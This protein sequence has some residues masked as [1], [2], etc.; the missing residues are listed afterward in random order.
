MSYLDE[1][2][3]ECFENKIFHDRRYTWPDNPSAFQGA[4]LEATAGL[5]SAS[6]EVLDALLRALGLRRSHVR[7]LLDVQT[8]QRAA[9]ANLNQNGYGTLDST[10]AGWWWW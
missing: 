1:G 2:G 8:K 10:G 3:G 6:L 9:P 7:S 4:I 5:H